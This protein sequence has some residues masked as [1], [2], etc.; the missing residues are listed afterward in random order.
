[1]Q[2]VGN[3]IPKK[4][5]GSTQVPGFSFSFSYYRFCLTFSFPFFFFAKESSELHF[6]GLQHV[7]W[8]CYGRNEFASIP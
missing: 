4:K 1:M 6:G 8:V 3:A 2:E 7:G 5:C